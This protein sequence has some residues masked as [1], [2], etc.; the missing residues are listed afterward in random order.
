ML[1]RGIES[2]D[3]LEMVVREGWISLRL[4]LF[5]I[6]HKIGWPV[7]C[8]VVVAMINQSVMS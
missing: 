1:E 5:G 8:S 2:F 4:R 7:V 3:F 6:L